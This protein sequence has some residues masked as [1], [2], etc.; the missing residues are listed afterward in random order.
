[1]TEQA[2]EKCGTHSTKLTGG[3]CAKCQA[4][5]GATIAPGQ[6]DVD[7]VAHSDGDFHGDGD[8]SEPV[9]KR[10]GEYELLQEVA[11]GGM[12]VIYKARHVKLNRI[13]ALKM[14]LSGRFSSKEELQRF[15][16]EAEAAAKLDHPG[17]VPVYEIG[18]FEDQ[19]F[20]AMKF[21]EGGSL[22]ERLQDFQAD[23]QA[24][25]AML[26]KVASAV[27][28]AHQ[29]G[30]L[31]RDL[32]PANILIDEDDQPRITDL[33]LAKN[34]TDGSNLTNTGA[35]LGTPS[36]MPPEQA[37]GDAA[38]TTAADVYSLGAIMYELLTGMPPFRGESAMET[39]LQVRDG[40][41]VPPRKRNA[42]IDRDLEVI[43][44][45]CLER[46][47]DERYASALALAKD[48]EA[49]LTNEPISVG[50]P[51]FLAQT[52]RW[53]RQNRRVA[54]IGFAVIMG[55][56]ITLPF[57]ATF[58][59]DGDF[60]DVYDRF[61]DSERPWLFSM[62]TIPRWFNLT[63]AL[64][65]VFVF[66][67]SLGFLNAIVG[68][69]KN[70]WRA[71]ATGALTSGVLMA[72]FSVLL[73]WMPLMRATNDDARVRVLTN[74]IWPKTDQSQSYRIKEA[75]KL[76]PGLEHIPQDERAKIVADRL[77]SDRLAAAPET[78]IMLFLLECF[79][80]IPVVY[81]TAIGYW[82]LLRGH[83]TWVAYLRYL[84]SWW[85][86]GTA[87][88]FWILIPLDLYQSV[89]DPLTHKLVKSLIPPFLTVIVWLVMKRWKR[90]QE[91]DTA[92]TVISGDITPA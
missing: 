35:V 36:Y 52:Q 34:T 37:T 33:G 72:V 59:T 54:Y 76:F 18:E 15:H 3:L 46:N 40:Q 82:L 23:P 22:A 42:G 47:P 55:V 69:P 20:F 41:L 57:A 67:P 10:F 39:V 7:D 6:T 4:I 71:L 61:P 74:A 84:L 53:F 56:L 88:L 13:A 44:L 66:W 80:M 12:G 63:M 45:K 31:H 90:S 68:Q 64:S 85:L 17:I 27:H 38:V 48:L 25:I 1:M 60:S 77:R 86:A 50:A 78:L 79:F 73:G 5:H 83:R 21:I 65:L 9:G 49:W 24:A 11:R 8:L 51:S 2:C 16:I 87:F 92:R 89:N 58:A 75:T 19:A 26:A 29:R 43:C 32:K 70:V 62:G 91:L 81:G 14:I 28:H 30:I